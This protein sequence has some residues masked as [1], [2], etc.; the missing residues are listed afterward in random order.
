MIDFFSDT[1]PEYAVTRS[2]D[3]VGITYYGGVPV[4]SLTPSA[5]LLLARQ[6]IEVV[7]PAEAIN[8]LGGPQ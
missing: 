8:T 5:A 2:G 4:M 6:L 1:G 3:H 7:T